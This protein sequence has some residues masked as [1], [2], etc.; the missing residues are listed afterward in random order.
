MCHHSLLFSSLRLSTVVLFPA[1]SAH[2]KCSLSVAGTRDFG[3]SQNHLVSLNVS[4][5]TVVQVL[6]VPQVRERLL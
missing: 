3:P 2:R 5:S 1:I 4:V 6:D